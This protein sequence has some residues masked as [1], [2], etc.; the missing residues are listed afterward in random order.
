MRLNLRAVCVRLWA[1]LKLW[2]YSVNCNGCL[3]KGGSNL[4]CAEVQVEMVIRCVLLYPFL[5]GG[6]IGGRDEEC[7]CS[8][9]EKPA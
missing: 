1:L 3:Q 5:E 2:C 9:K 4:T 7:M 8:Q 6:E